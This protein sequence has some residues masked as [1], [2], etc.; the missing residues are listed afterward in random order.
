MTT[1]TAYECGNPDCYCCAQNR[2]IIN[3]YIDHKQISRTY[4]NDHE[5][6]LSKKYFRA[7]AELEQVRDALKSANHQITDLRRRVW[8]Y[9]NE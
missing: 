2:Q 6:D 3:E 7:V 5:T 9:E 4:T 8:I 1:S